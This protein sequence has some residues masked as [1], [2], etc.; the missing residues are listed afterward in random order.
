[1]TSVESNSPQNFPATP[2]ASKPL[3]DHPATGTDRNSLGDHLATTPVNSQNSALVNTEGQ[4]PSGSTGISLPDVEKLTRSQAAHA[5]MTAGIFVF[6]V[7]GKMPV[8]TASGQRA[9]WSEQSTA[10]TNAAD[11]WAKG[12]WNPGGEN[13]EHRKGLGIDC[14]KSGV[15]VVDVDRPDEVPPA[16]RGILR[17]A[18]FVSTDAADLRRGHYYF[19]QP[20]GGIGCPKAAWGEIKG[21]GGYVILPPSPHAA[22]D[23]TWP[24][25]Q[26]PEKKYRST[27]RYLQVRHGRLSPLPSLIADTFG[28]HRDAKAA[29]SADEIASFVEKCRGSS[30]PY[31][32]GNIIKSF[33]TLTDRGEG[34]HPTMQAC[35]VWAAKAA[36]GGLIPADLAHDS[37]ESAFIQVKGDEA[38]P[39]EFEDMW[40]WA[41][42]QA[43]QE[44][45]ASFMAA[46][47]E[48]QMVY[49]ADR[50]KIPEAPDENL[51]AGQ[52]DDVGQVLD[53]TVFMDE[54]NLPLGVVDGTFVTRKPGEPYPVARAILTCFFT[55]DDLPTLRRWQDDWFLWE[56]GQWVQVS[57]E[58]QRDWFY[59]R[60][61]NAQFWVKK[62]DTENGFDK[63]PWN[64]KTTSI[65]QLIDAA[66]SVF[67]LNDKISTNTWIRS[68]EAAKNIVSVS[69]GLLDLK[70]RTVRTHTPDLF[71]NYALPFDYSSSAVCPEWDKFLADIMEH[72]P[73]A[74]LALQEWFGY[75]ISGRTDLHKIFLISGPPRGGKGTIARILQEVVGT[76]NACGANLEQLDGDTFGMWDFTENTLA[77]FGDVEIKGKMRAGIVGKLKEISGGDTIRVDRKNRQPWNGKIP[78]RLMMLS[79]HLPNFSDSSGGLA[80]RFINIRLIK[81]FY[82][83]EDLELEGRLVQELPG[84]LNWALDGLDR[85]ERQRKFTVS[86]GHE[87]MFQLQKESSEPEAMFIEQLCDLG[88]DFWITKEEL[89]MKWL[90]WRAAQGV[91]G[92]EGPSE[93]IESFSRKLFSAAPTVRGKRKMIAGK[94]QYVFA[95]IR[96]KVEPEPEPLPGV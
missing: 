21:I 71:N 61:A 23:Q 86:E 79:N 15:V 89:R 38:F 66:K 67:K 91:G 88:A 54:D 77:V 72:D 32:L 64:P 13:S 4:I 53:G 40:E 37:L 24:D 85:L 17:M 35:L 25:K 51:Y 49:E 78:A 8:K 29:A 46:R 48:R 26:T 18:P 73:K 95:G 20:E 50:D 12:Y 41:I 81:E 34:R 42:G 39:T 62:K 76:S 10:D 1:M 2:A 36:G 83:N 63:V 87:E 58:D 65:N 82:G 70:T 68:R 19:S 31:L 90:F 56:G 92:V 60:M 94:Q 59:K 57:P 30:D 93:T 43:T 16:W 80:K 27:A 33:H 3:G 6:P 5:Y 28:E 45:V 7:D 55:H 69:N 22:A 75:V 84:I 9:K 96:L 52:L 14:G 47:A 74:I 11:Q 44:E